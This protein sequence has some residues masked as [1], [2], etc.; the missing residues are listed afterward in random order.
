VQAELTCKPAKCCAIP[1][2]QTGALY[3]PLPLGRLIPRDRLQVL[4]GTGMMNIG[5]RVVEAGRSTGRGFEDLWEPSRLYAP[6]EHRPH[7]GGVFLHIQ[8]GMG[9][10]CECVLKRIKMR[11]LNDGGENI[12]VPRRPP[13]R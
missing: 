4:A 5:I 1:V 13:V 12:A 3:S 8:G 11:S 6:V 10:A 9:F 2:P 7:G